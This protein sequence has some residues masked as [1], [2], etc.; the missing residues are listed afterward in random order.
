MLILFF[1]KCV[2]FY[3]ALKISTILCLGSLSLCE[4]KFLYTRGIVGDRSRIEVFL[5]NGIKID[6]CK[7]LCMATSLVYV[8]VP[9][10]VIDMCEFPKINK[11]LYLAYLTFV[12]G[13]DRGDVN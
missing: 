12:Q 13:S 11:F 6:E 2:N 9:T 8:L 4:C 5:L 7:F 10:R 1:V 3:I